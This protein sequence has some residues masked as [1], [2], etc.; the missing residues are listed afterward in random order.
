[1]SNFEKYFKSK[2]K[3]FNEVILHNNINN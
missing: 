2:E 1:M 3:E